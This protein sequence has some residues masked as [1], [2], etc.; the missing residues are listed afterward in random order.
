MRLSRMT[1]VALATMAMVA[2]PASAKTIT[3]HYF[4]KQVSVKFTDAAG[5]VQN[6][7]K[8]PIAGDVGDQVGLAYV[9]NH[10]AHAKRWTASY[11]LRCVFRRSPGATCDAQIAIGGSMLL[12]NGAHPNF[13]A[14]FDRITINGGTGI[15]QRARGTL[16]SVSPGKMNNSDITI[17][18]RISRAAGG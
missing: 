7:R 17:Q 2:A 16:S 12:A 4:F 14:N 15:F 3:L 1:G 6:R 11:H 18:L 10:S 9:G 13:G 5:H 8:R